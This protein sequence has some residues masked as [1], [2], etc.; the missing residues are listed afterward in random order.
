MYAGRIVET[1][2]V[3]DVLDRS[4]HPYTL[5]LLGSSAATVAPGERLRQIDGSGAE[6][7]RA[8]ERMR[9]SVRDARA[10]WPSAPRSIRRDRS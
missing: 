1:G 5:G 10:R 6:H 4:R 2:T 7:R 3:D 8:P 9:R